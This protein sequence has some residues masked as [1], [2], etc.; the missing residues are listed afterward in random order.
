MT[1]QDRVIDF[2]TEE[3]LLEA[4]Q[5]LKDAGRGQEADALLVRGR[6]L[7]PTSATVAERWALSPHGLA[8]FDETVDRLHEATEAFPDSLFMHHIFFDILLSRKQLLEA[9]RIL[10]RLERL[11]VD[12]PNWHIAKSQFL[13]E[14]GAF[15]HALDITAELRS[16]Y[17]Y[18][19]YGYIVAGQVYRKLGRF[20]D[21]ATVLAAGLA[22]LGDAPGLLLDAAATAVAMSEWQR[23]FDHLV[24]FRRRYPEMEGGNGALGDALLLWRHAAIENDP[25]AQA[26]VFPDDFSRIALIDQDASVGE[27]HEARLAKFMMRFESVGIACEF[28]L[29]QRK[30]GAE[31]L[32]LLRWGNLDSTQLCAM[33]ANRLAGVGEP[34]YAFV[35]RHGEEYFVGDK[36]YFSMHSFVRTSEMSDEE[37]LRKSILRMRYLKDKLLADLEKGDKIFVFKPNTDRSPPEELERIFSCFGSHYPNAPILLVHKAADPTEIGTVRQHGPRMF[38]GFLDQINLMGPLISYEVWMDI[39][40]KAAALLWP[41]AG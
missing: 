16:R 40:R 22:A 28:G 19:A 31:P 9:D 23:A 32:S 41:D 38:E 2:D 10:A 14:Q 18:E 20:E 21:A 4:A 27:S 5:S 8:R 13:I 37:M 17:S 34:E 33:L 30:F 15:E 35:T 12:R 25:K 39:C 36:R 3:S 11:S 26:V 7:F 29:V 6:G 24:N 1:L